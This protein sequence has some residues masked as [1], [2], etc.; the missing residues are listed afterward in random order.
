MGR[1]LISDEIA[2]GSLSPCC[3]FFMGGGIWAALTVK[4]L[5]RGMGATALISD[6]P[7]TGRS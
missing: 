4:S 2:G 1:L 6:N 5:A 3:S 7:S